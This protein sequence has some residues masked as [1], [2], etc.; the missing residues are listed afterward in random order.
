MTNQFE[1][2]FVP[3]Q[4]LLR[5]EAGQRPRVPLD[6]AL[7]VSLIVFFVTL[8]VAGGA[9]FYKQQVDKQVIS[10]GEDLKAAEALFDTG[11]ISTYKELQ[12]KLTTAKTL[13]D[14][15]TIFSLIFDL[16]ETKAATNIGLTSL[17]FGQEGNSG[18]VSLLL[19]GQAPS[20][21]AVYFQMQKWRES[22]PVIKSV[23]MTSLSLEEASGIVSFS[24]KIALDAKTIG[25]AN[26]LA[27]SN[28]ANAQQAAAA[29]PSAF[30]EPSPLP[31]T[32]AP[33]STPVFSTSTKGKQAK[34][35]TT[36]L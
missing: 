8:A 22:K 33:T 4:P 6:L 2:A 1:T 13:V 27:A 23:D 15:H 30:T 18:D 5:V 12:V 19:T 9:F 36:D 34:S 11:K 28:A 21:E 16:I 31:I 14:S 3:Q 32:P 25:Y 26:M 20:Y 35:T 7:I 29:A 24:V 17:T 10:R